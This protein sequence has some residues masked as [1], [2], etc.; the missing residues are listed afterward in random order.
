V[1]FYNYDRET[2]VINLTAQIQ[3]IKKHYPIDHGDINYR[4]ENNQLVFLENSNLLYVSDTRVGA[5][6]LEVLSS[7]IVIRS[8]DCI[9]LAKPPGSKLFSALPLENDGFM[10]FYVPIKHHSQR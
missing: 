6:S 10:L 1:K 4:S 3:V 5:H 7:S 2:F 8:F 9:N